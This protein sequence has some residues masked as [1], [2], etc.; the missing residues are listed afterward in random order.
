M[1]DESL[2]R[3]L[4]SIRSN[5][6]ILN[7]DGMTYLKWFASFGTLLYMIRDKNLGVEYTQ[8]I[9]ISII[10]PYN[11]EK[12]ISRF[13]EDGFQIVTIIRNDLTDEILF[14]DFKSPNGISLDLFFWIECN[15]HLWHTYDYWAE[16]N[17]N[18]IPGKYHFKSLPNWMVSGDPYKYQWFNE[19]LEIKIPKLYGTLLDYWYPH[20]FIPDNEFGQSRTNKIIELKNCLNLTEVLSV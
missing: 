2:M 15:G 10:A 16:R 8:D 11:Q 20:W 12:I 9:D 14:V 19:E 6:D 5:L 1:D 13:E 18:G 4:R 7:D 17:S 3:D